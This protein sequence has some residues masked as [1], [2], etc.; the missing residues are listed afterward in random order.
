MSQWDEIQFWASYGYERKKV[1]IGMVSGRGG[2]WDLT[3]DSRHEAYIWKTKDGW[4]CNFQCPDWW[5]T[6]S[7]LD[8]LC[9]LVQDYI[10]NSGPERA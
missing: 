3:V 6:K 7:D 9:E 10:E 1:E 8:V 5:V 4:V 2:S